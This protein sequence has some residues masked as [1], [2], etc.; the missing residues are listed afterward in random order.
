MY[1]TAETQTCTSIS[2]LMAS[3]TRFVR[4]DKEDV[5]ELLKKSMAGCVNERMTK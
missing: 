2:K 4:R 3:E 1:Y 5:M